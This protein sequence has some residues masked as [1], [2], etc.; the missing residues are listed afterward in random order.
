MQRERDADAP[1]GACSVF[2]KK[3]VMG[4]PLDFFNNFKLKPI[5]MVGMW[6][7]N[8]YKPTEFIGLKITR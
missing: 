6:V 4:V 8:P 7:Y 5:D 1:E 3:N 2:C